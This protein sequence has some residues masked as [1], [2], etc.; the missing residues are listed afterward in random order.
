MGSE[1][2][3]AIECLKQDGRFDIRYIDDRKIAINGIVININFKCR[4]V[5]KCM[6]RILDKYKYA[7][8]MPLEVLP[9]ED[10]DVTELLKE[11]PELETF[12]TEWVK[13]WGRLRDRLSEIAEVLRRYPWMAEAVRET[14][15]HP[16]LVEVY[17]ALDRSEVCLI[18]YVKYIVGV[19]KSTRRSSYL[20]A[21]L[22][23]GGWFVGTLAQP[24]L[25]V[26]ISAA[27]RQGP[28]ARCGACCR[29]PGFVLPMVSPNTT[30]FFRL[31]RT[32]Q[33]LLTHPV[34]RL[35]TACPP[36]TARLY[37]RRGRGG[38]HGA[39]QPP[40]FSARRSDG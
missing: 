10:S 7:A 6:E 12:G 25:A 33:T 16:Y 31:F 38:R 5:T 34:W 2:E 23:G 39:C 21:T 1:L 30:S 35:S 11:Y 14:D 13:K 28:W 9:V 18:D 26:R 27:G 36:P 29:M 4:D 24:L 15:P 22:G 37:S 40:L 17:V 20:P 19:P 32:H 8:A 3:Q